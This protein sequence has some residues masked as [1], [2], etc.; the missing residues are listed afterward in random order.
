MSRDIVFL[1]GRDLL[2]RIRD[3][4]L[5]PEAIQAIAGAAGGP[6]WLILYHLDMFLFPRWIGIREDPL[7]L[8]GSSI[9][10]WRFAALSSGDPEA[11]TRFRDAYIHQRYASRRPTTAEVS[12]ECR[13]IMDAYL[14]K[15]EV[16]GIFRHPFLRLNALAVRCRWPLSSDSPPLLGTGLALAAVANL[17]GRRV[18]HRLFRR[19]LFFHPASRPFPPEVKGFPAERIPLSPENL[20]KVLLASGS[21]PFVMQAEGGIPGAPPGTYRDGGLLDY[22]LDLPFG[23]TADSGIVLYPHYTDRIIPGWLDKRLTWRRP[24]A[25]NIR[26]VLLVAPSREFI[27]GL[28]HG[29]IPDRNDFWSFEGRDD[30]RIAYWEKAVERGRVLAEEFHDAV[31]S[32]RIRRLV[33][34]LPCREG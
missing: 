17:V 10:A 20:K 9:G 6:K 34:P 2:D 7:F 21:I 13:R 25:E 3:E 4:G 29:K 5:R 12:L 11:L 27:A 30:E 16:E 33:R 22:H 19:A 28:P 18:L 23:A 8:V 14:G 32:G 24:R 15:A 31:E 1:A 26:N